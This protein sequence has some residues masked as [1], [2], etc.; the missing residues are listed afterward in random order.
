VSGK[1][2]KGAVQRNKL[3]RMIYG[4]IE[5]IKSELLKAD[6]LVIT[7]KNIA[8]DDKKLL[9]EELVSLFREIINKK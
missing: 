9:R 2:V 7:N 5:E 1:I 6:Y 4:V 3:K 8:L